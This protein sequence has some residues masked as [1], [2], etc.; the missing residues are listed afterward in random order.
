[1]DIVNFRIYRKAKE[2]IFE[3]HFWGVI[4]SIM[5]YY[6]ELCPTLLLSGEVRGSEGRRS[7][8]P[9]L[10]GLIIKRGRGDLIQE[11]LEEGR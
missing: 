8:D 6:G 9:V 7:Y 11:P 5:T 10:R 2:S 3:E 1:M 4:I